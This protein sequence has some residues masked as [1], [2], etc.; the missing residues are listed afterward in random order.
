MTSPVA[1][2][3][4][5]F[6]MKAAAAKGLPSQRSRSRSLPDADIIGITGISTARRRLPVGKS[7]ESYEYLF[8]AFPA[9]LTSATGLLSNRQKIFRKGAVAV[10]VAETFQLQL[11]LRVR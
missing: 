5:K 2:H 1:G 4:R 7:S 10:V 8:S 3:F 11:D 9:A 6:I